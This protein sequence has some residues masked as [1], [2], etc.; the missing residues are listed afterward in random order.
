MV[1]AA[2]GI[3]LMV[4]SSSISADP[5]V[6]TPAPPLVVK[7]LDGKVFNLAALRGRVVVIN[8]WATWCGPCR[9]EMPLL[10]DFYNR[11]H[12]QGVDLL[13]LSAD[14]LRDA[15]SVRAVMKQFAYPAA[16]LKEARDNGFGP[17]RAVP[18]T[19][20]IGPDGTLRTKLWAGGTAV[21]EQSLENAVVPL[22]AS[23]GHTALT[24]GWQPPSFLHGVSLRSL[25]TEAAPNRHAAPSCF[26]NRLQRGGWSPGWA[27]QYQRSNSAAPASPSGG[28]QL[29]KSC[30]VVGA[31]G[32]AL[33]SNTIVDGASVA[34]ACQ[35][36]AGFSRP[37][38]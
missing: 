2:S 17:A 11:Y 6:G 31:Y 38:V 8:L 29:A 36:P 10:N 24:T 30:S 22:P 23:A 18:V 28:A 33:H 27:V 1:L 5:V 14:A 25:P 7:E 21:T 26:L 37:R 3:A 35:V 34:T 19:Y 32:P 13:G 15:D 4:L 12:T 20:I 9:A 16:L